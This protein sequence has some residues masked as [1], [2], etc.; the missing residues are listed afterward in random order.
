MSSTSIQFYGIVESICAGRIIVLLQEEV[1]TKTKVKE[2][3]RIAAS[4]SGRIKNNKIRITIGDKV[5]LNVNSDN[6]QKGIIVF[7]EK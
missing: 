3:T 2:N 1:K 7:R 6:L 4:L 5:R